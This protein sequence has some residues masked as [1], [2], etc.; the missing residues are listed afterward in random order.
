MPPLP[1]QIRNLRGPR[2]LPTHYY[3]HKAHPTA[4]SGHRC[5]RHRKPPRGSLHCADS[6]DCP[7]ARRQIIQFIKLFSFNKSFEVCVTHKKWVSL[8]CKKK[9]KQKLQKPRAKIQQLF[10]I[11][12]LFSQKNDADHAIYSLMEVMEHIHI[13]PRQIGMAKK[14]NCKFPPCI[15]STYSSFSHSLR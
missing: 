13:Q 8:Q 3:V 5:V 2:K 7:T 14:A 9:T 10:Q 1:P 12:E 15:C 4:F 6:F 11:C